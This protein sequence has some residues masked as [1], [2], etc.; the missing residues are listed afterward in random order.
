MM[1]YLRKK[2]FQR[3]N[4]K[5]KIQTSIEMLNSLYLFRLVKPPFMHS[6]E[7]KGDLLVYSKIF[8]NQSM[9]LSIEIFMLP[10]VT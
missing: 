5:R 4:I 10:F 9:F 2:I 3:L 8:K 6:F 7:K 1:K